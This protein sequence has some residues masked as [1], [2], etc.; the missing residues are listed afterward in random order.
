[1]KMTVLQGSPHKKGSSNLL[2]AEFIKG[3]L[4][5][6]H[7]VEVLDVAHMDIHPCIGCEHCGMDGE[8]LHHDDNEMVEKA[9]LSTDLVVFVTPI[10]YFG[11]SSQLKTVVDRFYSYNTKLK[12]K[13][14]K[15][16]LI[17][18]AWEDEPEVMTWIEGHYQ[19]ICDYMHFE[20]CGQVLGT[21]CGNLG[22]TRA[23]S[24]MKEAY[25]LGR[26]M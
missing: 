10:Y 3:A 7:E 16:V 14:L 25:E 1:M 4:E 15:A 21:G 20:N 17:T 2:A 6:G 13:G 9:L 26:S 5:K 18:A 12:Q 24:H 22:A 19:K 11:M 8:C 23:S